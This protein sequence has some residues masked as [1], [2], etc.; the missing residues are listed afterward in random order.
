MFF[1]FQYTTNVI[2]NQLNENK[3]E[4]FVLFFFLYSME[5]KKVPIFGK[6]TKFFLN[7]FFSVQL[8]TTMI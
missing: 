4:I 3:F 6:H 1:I 2:K 5:P 7:P 8:S